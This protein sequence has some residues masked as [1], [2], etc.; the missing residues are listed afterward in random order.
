MNNMYS[1]FNIL[2]CSIVKFQ[3]ETLLRFSIFLDEPNLFNNIEAQKFIFLQDIKKENKFSY[4]AII[5]KDHKRLGLSVL[6]FLSE[7]PDYI[8][9][10]ALQEVFL[11]GYT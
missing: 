8:D 2:S 5:F 10:E 6:K 11:L 9:K 1:F 7:Y 4:L 3:L